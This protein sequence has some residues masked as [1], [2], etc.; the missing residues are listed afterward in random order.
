[1]TT[2]SPGALAVL[3][4]GLDHPEGV[5]WDPG[6]RLV[7]GGEAGQIYLIDTSS[8]PVVSREVASTGGYI[9]GIALDADG[10]AYVCDAAR[11]SVLRIGL[12]DGTVEEYSAGT[13]ARPMVAPNFPVFDG[14][15]RM[16]VSDSGEWGAGDGVIWMVEPGGEAVIADEQCRLFPNGLALDAE[17]SWLYVVESNLPGVVRLRISPDGTLGEREIVVEMPRTVPDG[18]A[19][20]A[21][22]SLVIAC[23]RPDRLYHWNAGTLSV[24]ADDWSGVTLGAP[25]NAA[26]FGADLDRLVVANL[27]EQMLTEVGVDLKGSPL[28]R[29]AGLP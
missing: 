22:G 29:P 5:A 8:S 7:T 19:L 28:F 17:R 4:G 10:R 18:L 6:G 3:V 11:Q 26:F 14:R 23:Y 24:L 21:D 12:D 2:T 16:Y 1:M 27:G 9:L 25:T 13:A 15:G 20:A